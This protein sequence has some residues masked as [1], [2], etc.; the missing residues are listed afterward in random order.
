MGWQK[1]GQLVD[2]TVLPEQCGFV[3]HSAGLRVRIA[4]NLAP[5]IDGPR[6]AVT[7]TRDRTQPAHF[8][9]LHEK[10]LIMKRNLPAWRSPH[11]ADP[12][13]NQ[14][15]VAERTGHAVRVSGEDA[16]IA[17]CAAR[18]PKNCM[19][20]GCAAN[21]S[22]AFADRLSFVIESTGLRTSKPGG[23]GK[24]AQ[25]PLAP[26]EC[27]A[28]G[29][30][31]QLAFGIDRFRLRQGKTAHRG[32][33]P[34]QQL[35]LRS[36]EPGGL[37]AGFERVR[38]VR[39]RHLPGI[40][41]GGRVGMAAVQGGQPTHLSL[42]PQEDIRDIL[43]P[44]SPRRRIRPADDLPPIVQSSRRAFRPAQRAEVGHSIAGG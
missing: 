35:D 12:A 34:A 11:F 7:D 3:G 40:V 20:A 22:F 36:E 41:D 8:A 38:A 18:R 1:C 43:R 25:M 32:R 31:D 13:Y 33:K 15:G 23:R 17:G 6:L 14:S 37:E 24:P 16:Q 44:F 4:D 26:E 28:V 9:I 19:G 10:S 30:S 2:V 39:P 42:F 21:E 29:N 5:A 27:L